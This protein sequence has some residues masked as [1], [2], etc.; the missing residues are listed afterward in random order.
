M[1]RT[2]VEVRLKAGLAGCRRLAP[3]AV[4][5]LL[6]GCANMK[7]SLAERATFDLGCPVRESD[8]TEI[9]SGQYGVRACGCRAT[10]VS[11][12]TWTLNVAS[13]ESCGARGPSA[14]KA[15][16]STPAR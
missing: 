5:L 12:P 9:A 10:Y 1:M 11:Y 14:S 13:G 8:V 7:Q 4:L 3:G 2:P 16:P 6:V 15:A